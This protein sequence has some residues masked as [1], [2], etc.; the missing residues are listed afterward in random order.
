M[1]FQYLKW[2]ESLAAAL[3]NF[4]NLM[5][6]FNFLLL[7]ASGD[8]DKVLEWMK[9]LQRRGFIDERFDLEQFREQLEH[10]AIIQRDGE[11]YSLTARGEQQ[12]RK[13]SLKLIFN[14]L[15]RG[16]FGQHRTPHTGDGGE[17]LPETRQYRFGDPITQIDAFATINNAVKRGG[18][19]EIRLGEQDFEVFEAEHTSSCATVLLIDLSHS[20]ILYGE[21]RIT[22]AKQVALA[23]YELITTQFPKDSLHVAYFGDDARMIEVRDIPYLK[24]GPFHTNTKAGL[25][26]AQNVLRNQKHPNKQV[27]MITDGKP[28][29]IFENGRLYKNSFGLDPKIV[30]QTLEEAAACK[31]QGIVITTFMVTE[32]PYLVQFVEE[33]SRIN[34]GRAY[35]SSLDNLGNYI[36]ADYAKNRRRNVR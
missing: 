7:Q 25:Q 16:G 35:Y 12:I 24:V 17:R 34:S 31:R 28:S 23:L 9:Y 15:K 20:M 32:D 11:S 33:L 5:N 10:Q 19:D 1:N 21:D 4:S 27:F 36:F 26:L 29:A 22:P 14:N 18:V 2:D 8:V 3:Q 30:N 13:E 6:L